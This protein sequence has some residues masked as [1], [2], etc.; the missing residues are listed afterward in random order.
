MT[1]GCRI[2]LLARSETGG[3]ERKECRKERGNARVVCVPGS[4]RKSEAQVTG[5]RVPFVSW[6]VSGRESRAAGQAWLAARRLQPLCWAFWQPVGVAGLVVVWL[7]CYRGIR[8]KEGHFRKRDTSIITS[9][10]S[11]SSAICPCC[12]CKGNVTLA[13][14][15][16]PVGGAVMLQPCSWSGVLG[17]D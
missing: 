17:I 1:N 14:A 10:P 5:R 4:K 9:R 8:G 13:L 12:H 16:S 6:N 15:T 2:S 11:P 3:S 7:L